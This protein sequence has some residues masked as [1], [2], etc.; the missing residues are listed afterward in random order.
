MYSC[1]VFF[2]GGGG[3]LGDGDSILEEILMIGKLM[4]FVNFYVL[5]PLSLMLVGW[6]L[7]FGE[8]KRMASS[9]SFGEA[10]VF[11]KK[12]DRNP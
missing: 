8:L 12:I 2:R 11:P 9:W 3:G 7:R 4:K 1:R 6:T 5:Y 10:I